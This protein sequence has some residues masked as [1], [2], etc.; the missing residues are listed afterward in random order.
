VHY[1]LCRIHKTL[2]VSPAMAVGICDTLVSMDDIARLIGAASPAKPRGPYK[3]RSLALS[4][5]DVQ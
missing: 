2:K 5:P 1:N 4:A 3:K